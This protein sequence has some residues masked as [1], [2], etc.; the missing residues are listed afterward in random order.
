MNSEYVNSV[1][2]DMGKV[3][4]ITTFCTSIICNFENIEISDLMIDDFK[5]S[6]LYK[7][8]L[9]GFILSLMVG[10]FQ[11]KATGKVG[12]L[13]VKE[14]KLYIAFITLFIVYNMLYIEPKN[15]EI[16]HGC[17]M[18]ENTVHETYYLSKSTY[19]YLIYGG[20]CPTPTE[21]IYNYESN[22]E[23]ILTDECGEKDEE[24]CK[25]DTMC[26]TFI[27]GYKSAL[28]FNNTLQLRNTEEHK[29]IY[30]ETIHIKDIGECYEYDLDSLIYEY[31]KTDRE[32]FKNMMNVIM[33]MY[34]III[35]L[36]FCISMIVIKFV[37]KEKNHEAVPV[38]E[39][40]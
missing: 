13:I 15:C 12:I 37:K 24:C 33:W 11:E 10:L 39:S 7:V 34:Y 35:S 19:Y 16:Y 30:K 31:I 4:D 21:L 6:I 14:T 27:T 1:I 17:G 38:K 3:Y 20:Y 2:T 18:E 5:L 26:N 40:V 9:F 22:H 23:N 32:Y 8:C 36:T 29:G 25:V 28:K